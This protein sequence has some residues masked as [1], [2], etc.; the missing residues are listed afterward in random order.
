ML[1]NGTEESWREVEENTKLFAKQGVTILYGLWVL[2]HLEGCTN[3]IEH[4]AIQRGYN[5]TS[6]VPCTHLW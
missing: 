1:C 5:Y 4:E 6:R 3:F 2:W